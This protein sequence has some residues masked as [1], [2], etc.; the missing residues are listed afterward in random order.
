MD[1]ILTI[2]KQRMVQHGMSNRCQHIDV[3]QSLGRWSQACTVKLYIDEALADS[4]ASELSAE[5]RQ[6]LRTVL[7]KFPVLIQR[8][9]VK[10]DVACSSCS[11]ISFMCTYHLVTSAKT[12]N[13]KNGGRKQKYF[14]NDCSQNGGCCSSVVFQF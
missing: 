9:L 3:I 5:G 7:V 1:Y 2:Y 11:L 8:L 13:S 14:N 10:G 4:S 6:Q 12:K